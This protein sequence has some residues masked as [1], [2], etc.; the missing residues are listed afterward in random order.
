MVIPVIYRYIPARYQG[1]FALYFMH[2]NEDG[3]ISLFYIMYFLI[4][5]FLIYRLYYDNN[6]EVDYQNMGINRVLCANTIG[7]LILSFGSIYSIISRVADYLIL[8]SFVI[9]LPIALKR[10][11]K[12][13]RDIIII[14]LC[15]LAFIIQM[16]IFRSVVEIRA[17]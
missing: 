1:K 9:L 14:I 5:L 7:L 16:R 10:Y 11:K 4:T 12:S 8:S 15:L 13:T 3:S 6:N 2:A 17:F